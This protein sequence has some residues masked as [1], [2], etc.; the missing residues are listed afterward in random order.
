MKD[1]SPRRSQSPP[2]D[3]DRSPSKSDRDRRS[4]KSA[5]SNKLD[6]GSHRVISFTE[7]GDLS[8][9]VMG[10]PGDRRISRGRTTGTAPGSRRRAATRTRGLLPPRREGTDPTKDRREASGAV[11]SPARTRA[12][13]MAR[14]ATPG[15]GS[16][17]RRAFA[18]IVRIT[19]RRAEAQRRAATAAPTA[20]AR[21]TFEEVQSQRTHRHKSLQKEL[22][23]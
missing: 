15:R 17:S 14:T 11:T 13:V 9:V 2:R 10:A 22:G 5:K 12:T 8:R 23:T 7:E 21:R 1:R 3:K 20:T 6:R 19:A 16:S 18:V 4:V